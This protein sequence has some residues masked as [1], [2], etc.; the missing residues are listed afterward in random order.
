MSIAVRIVEWLS[1][2]KRRAD[3]DALRD[4]IA[5]ASAVHLLDLGGGAGA[6]TE[7][8]AS[9]CGE[10]VILE[11][12]A[13]KVSYGRQ[14]RPHIRFVEG[15]A[16]AIPFPDESFD[17]VTSVVAFHHMENPDRVLDEIHRV[18]RPGGRVALFEFAPSEAPGFFSRWLT[19]R[20]GEHLSFYRPDELRTKLEAHAFRAVSTTVGARGYSVVG[21]REATQRE[22]AIR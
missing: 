1:V 18:L 17:R 19:A 9:G 21:S 2:R 4:L 14:R 13:K 5:P 20:H 16:E 7:R 3:L 22:P 8:F 12:N 15:R 6:V 10:I 11:T